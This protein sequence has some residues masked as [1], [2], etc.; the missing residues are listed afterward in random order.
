MFWCCWV[1]TVSDGD[2][3]NVSSLIYSRSSLSDAD[4]LLALD[5]GNRKVFFYLSSA[6][7]A[8]LMTFLVLLSGELRGLLPESVAFEDVF[9]KNFGVFVDELD[10]LRTSKRFSFGLNKLCLSMF[11]R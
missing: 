1:G 2:I 8:F 5:C 11:P 6:S 9:F 3:N 4:K 10:S 7:V